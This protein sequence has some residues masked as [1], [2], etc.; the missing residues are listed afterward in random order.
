MGG[1][2]LEYVV[3]PECLNR[4]S[5]PTSNPSRILVIARTLIRLVHLIKPL[6]RVLPERPAEILLVEILQAPRLVPVRGDRYDDSPGSF[7]SRPDLGMIDGLRGQ[8]APHYLPVNLHRAVAL[9]DLRF[10]RR[11]HPHLLALA[12]PAVDYDSRPRP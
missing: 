11:A 5:T 7:E 9:D 10:P 4:E 12:P 3:I 2:N 6:L 8:V 1:F